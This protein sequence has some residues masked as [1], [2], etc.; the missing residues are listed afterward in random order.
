ME[1]LH[2]FFIKTEKKEW[3]EN[4]CLVPLELDDDF[5]CTVK[6]AGKNFLAASR[7]EFSDGTTVPAFVD[8]DD[9][10]ICGEDGRW[11]YPRYVSITTEL[12]IYS[13]YWDS[14]TGMNTEERFYLSIAP[15]SIL[16]QG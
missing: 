3:Y 11:Y 16:Q 5:T 12:S 4:M 9:E 10:K 14:P 15:I 8:I 7:V 13:L 2:R 6:I 1:N